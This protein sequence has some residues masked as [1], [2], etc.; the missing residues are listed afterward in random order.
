MQNDDR[1]LI[2][3]KLE[4]RAGSSSFFVSFNFYNLFFYFNIPPGEFLKQTIFL[5]Q[6]FTAS[7]L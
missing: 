3:N 7:Q 5:P 2:V 6:I 4:S 1:V